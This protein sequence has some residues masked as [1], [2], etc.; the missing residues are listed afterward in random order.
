MKTHRIL[1]A[2]V[3]PCLLLALSACSNEK[4]PQILPAIS[5]KA[6]E[7]EIVSSKALWESEVGS[8]IR[9]VLQAEYP[10]TPQ[11]ETKYRI[12]NVPPEGFVNVF[13]LH[14]NILYVHIADTCA[15]KFAISK[16][17]WAAPQTMVTIYAPDEA[18]AAEIGRAHV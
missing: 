1:L 11:K 17:V 2:T 7:V 13:R 8:A 10:F 5:G 12:Y 9:T 4:K 15:K 18:S 6:G 3:L 14:R 16:D